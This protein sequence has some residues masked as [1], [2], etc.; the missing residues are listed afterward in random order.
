MA[1]QTILVVDD[2]KSILTLFD[3]ALRRRGYEVHTAD[4]GEEA[5]SMFGQTPYWVVLTDLRL[6]GID[7]LEVCRRIRSDFPFTCVFAMTGYVSVYELSACRE[8]GFEDYFIKPINLEVVGR[9]ID[10]AFARVARWR[11]GKQIPETVLTET[12]AR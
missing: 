10:H 11:S 8:V 12:K 9:E 3:K 7:G 5:V 2:E 4:S 6:T 1:K